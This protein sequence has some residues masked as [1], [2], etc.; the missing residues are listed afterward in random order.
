MTHGL[1]FK[2][3]ESAWPLYGK[4]AN[5]PLTPEQWWTEVITRTMLHAGAAQSGQPDFCASWRLG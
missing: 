5:P 4:H 1:A 3:M 2:E